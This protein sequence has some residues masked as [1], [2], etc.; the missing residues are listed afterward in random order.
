M[1]ATKRITSLVLTLIMLF[2][3]ACTGVWTPHAHAEEAM[4]LDDLQIVHVNPL[5]ADVYTEDDLVKPSGTLLYGDNTSGDGYYDTKTAGEMIRDDLVAR[6]AT[7]IVDI[8]G[9]YNSKDTLQ[10]DAVDMIYDVLANAMV[11]TGNPVEGDYILWHY[12]GFEAN[13]TNASYDS[14]NLYLTLTFTM[15]YHASA[16]QEAEMN[17]AVSK[18]LGE[19]NVSGKDDYTKL[20]AIYDYI[21]ANVT[22][23]H[24]TDD[25]SKLKHSAY[26][27]L[28]KKT[29]VCQG[30]ALLLYRLALE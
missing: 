16:A 28:V 7:I 21:T 6:D 3:L 8:Y 19:L 22:Y 30:Y 10:E 27:A 17:T 5:Y 2:S 13:M 24:S 25:S 20:K 1:K 18:L 12:G 23:D 15:T 9:K 26:A 14:T 29:A 4:P 11:H